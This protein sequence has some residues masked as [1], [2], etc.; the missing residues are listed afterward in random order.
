MPPSKTDTIIIHVAIN[1]LGLEDEEYRKILWALFRLRPLPGAEKPSSK[2]LTPVQAKRLIKH[3]ESM[4][5]VST[6]RKK[7]TPD[8]PVPTDGKSQK[9]LALWITLYKDGVVR[10]GSNRSMMKFVKRQTGNEH[11]K[12]CDRADKD[13]V[14]EALKG[15]ANREDVS[16]G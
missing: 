1:Q 12:W 6:I 5:F 10:N 16:L 7:S 3:F 2:Q 4:G 9:I 11:L 15:M 8:I 13:K 14:I